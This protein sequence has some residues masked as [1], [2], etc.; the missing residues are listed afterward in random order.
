MRQIP[1]HTVALPHYRLAAAAPSTPDFRALARPVDEV[2]T[3]AFPERDVLLRAVASERHPG[4]TQDELIQVICELGHDRYDPDRPGDQYE[5]VE[6]R[7]GEIRRGGFVFRDPARRPEAV[8][9]I[10]KIT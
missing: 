8:L 1:I 10:L 9:A 6:G 2:L 7:E 3:R 4:R 5:T